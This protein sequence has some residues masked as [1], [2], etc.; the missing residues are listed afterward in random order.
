M[1]VVKPSPSARRA[2]RICLL[3]AVVSALPA[4]CVYAADL[5]QNLKSG[6]PLVVAQVAPQKGKPAPQAS[7]MAPNASGADAVNRL[8]SPP[9]PD[10]DIPLPRQ[11][12]ATRP[13]DSPQD[14]PRIWGRQE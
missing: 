14:Q 3:S 6:F 11:D 1:S 2:Y 10:P 4:V 13:A 9:P 8:L 7:P 5:N 12:L